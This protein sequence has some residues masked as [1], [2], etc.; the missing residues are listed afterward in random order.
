MQDCTSHDHKSIAAIWFPLGHPSRWWHWWENTMPFTFWLTSGRNVR[1]LVCMS[2]HQLL[3]ACLPRLCITPHQWLFILPIKIKHNEV[4][5]G[6]IAWPVITANSK[7]FLNFGSPLFFFPIPLSPLLFVCVPV[8]CERLQHTP[9][10][11]K[12]KKKQT[13]RQKDN[14]VGK[15]SW[16]NCNNRF[17][18]MWTSKEMLN[19]AHPR[20]NI[21]AKWRWA[22]YEA[23]AAD[24]DGPK[25]WLTRTYH[26]QYKTQ[27]ER[28][29]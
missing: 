18:T 15:G 24:T 21:W 13:D 8:V 14:K 19:C 12:I 7:A 10:Y 20:N 1:A 6:M 26:S 25:D 4:D 5:E 2:T 27:V 9:N 22:W 17:V 23:K 28:R 16:S 3:M 11:K 29:N